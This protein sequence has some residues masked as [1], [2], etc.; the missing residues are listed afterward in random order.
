MSKYPSPDTLRWDRP[1]YDDGKFVGDCEDTD[2]EGGE[3]TEEEDEF[4]VAAPTE[5]EVWCMHGKL[6]A[7]GTSSN[8]VI[9]G[10]LGDCWFISALAIMGAKEELIRKCFWRLDD[11]KEFG[12]FVCVFYKDSKL[13]FVLI[14]DRIPVYQKTG[15]VVFGMCK[16]CN[17]LWVPLLE[18]AYAKLHGCY[19]ALIGGYSHYALADMTGFSPRL[20]G[21]KEGYM[22]FSDRFDPEEVWKILI[23]YM[24][25][26]E[27]LV[28]CSIQ[29]KASDGPKVE[30]SAGDGL[31][32]GHA[33]SF[34]D[35]GEVKLPDR[36]DPVRLVKLRNPWGRGEWEG[37]WSDNSDEF[38]KYEQFIKKVFVR[39][40]NSEVQDKIWLD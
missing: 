8:D 21:L 22:G 32:M 3:D 36:S 26:W 39:E 6:F 34:L 33:Y 5:N 12:L 7:G 29:A 15:K 9:Q 24:K 25:H 38:E 17:E 35:V 31:I 14:D 13:M 2:D 18:K 27:S 11:F 40:G 28:G 4:A 1:Q 30:A 37:P 23:K 20:I 16:D 10:T 19:K